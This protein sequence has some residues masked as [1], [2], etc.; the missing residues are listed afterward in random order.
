[1][2]NYNRCSRRSRSE[3]RTFRPNQFLA[4]WHEVE[5][6][7]SQLRQTVT[8]QIEQLSVNSVDF[9]EQILGFKPYAYQKEFAELFENNQF[10]AARWCRQSGKTE[11]ISALLLRYAV[12]HPNA[13][14]GI[15]GPSWRQTKRIITRIATFAHKLP[16]GIVFKP[17][18]TQIQ[19]ANG[20]II[21]AFPNNPETIR[22]PTLNVV[23][24][25]ELNFVPNDQ[26]LYDAIL[27]TLISTD[28]KFVCSSTPFNTDS[29]FYKIFTH[30]NFGHFKTSHVTYEKAISPNGP[31]KPNIIQRIKTQMGDDPSRWQR[32]MQ[33]EWVEDDNVWLTQ[34]LIA[35]CIGT[36]K[37]YSE[38]LDPLDPEVTQEGEF[39]AGLDLA[40]TKTTPFSR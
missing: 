16:P 40:Q 37:N 34:S 17:Q 1:M 12:V 3:A 26:E 4:K 5:Q 15:V 8:E 36:V 11:I 19:F 27:Y 2:R 9:F 32:E 30:K 13:A 14:I 33:A 23:Y 6:E 35:S 25:D 22:G 39:F 31:I 7:H 21:E 38:E 29:V 10:T 28:G 20:S 24:A 18:K